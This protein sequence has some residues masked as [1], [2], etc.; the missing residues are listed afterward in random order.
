MQFVC[1]DS[2]GGQISMPE[3]AILVEMACYMYQNKKD[4][5]NSKSSSFHG[6]LQT[7]F[8]TV[9]LV[10]IQGIEFYG[11]YVFDGRKKWIRFSVREEFLKCMEIDPPSFI[12]DMF[13]AEEKE[14]RSR[15][16]E[17]SL[18]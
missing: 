11:D 14:A 13:L 7:E 4:R 8:A 2:D 15:I 1:I 16:L 12:G 17:P 6:I 9:L 18:N 3:T 5:V 10:D